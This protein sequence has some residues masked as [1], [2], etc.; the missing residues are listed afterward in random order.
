MKTGKF[1]VLTLHRPSNVD[2][3]QNLIDIFS[4]LEIIQK[5]IKLIF[6]VHPRSLKNIKKSKK[7]SAI[8]NN[9]PN[10]IM[11][12]PYGYFDFI[13][14]FSNSKFVITDSGSLQQETT[15]LNIPCIT[16]RENTE[17]P[18]TITKG[19]NV[20]AGRDKTKILKYYNQIKTGKFKQAQKIEFWDG[21]TAQRIVEILLT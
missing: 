16:I 13:N 10:I 4:A 3:E 14:L 8:L 2:N 9:C 11:T 15:F 19:S 1:G 17:R 6:P 21:Y 18:I 5:D 7:V 12:E 20:L